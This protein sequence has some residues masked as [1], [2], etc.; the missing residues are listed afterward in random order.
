MCV[1]QNVALRFDTI[2]MFGTILAQCCMFGTMFYFV[3]CFAQCL[4]FGT[5]V[6][7]WHNV[8]Y[9]K[10]CRMVTGKTHPKSYNRALR[11]H[12]GT[13][14]ATDLVLYHQKMPGTVELSTILNHEK[15][16]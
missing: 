8:A 2:R 15:N 14:L 16:K 1:C 5:M 9:F 3:L 13:G 6:Y 4:M 11:T 12:A 7:V 10:Q